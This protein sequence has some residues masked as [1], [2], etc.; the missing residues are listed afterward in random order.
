[1]AVAGKDF[2][3]QPSKFKAEAHLPSF[4][5]GQL[6]EHGP[7]APGELA[8][9][10]A[11]GDALELPA[12]RGVLGYAL[13]APASRAGKDQLAGGQFESREGVAIAIA[14]GPL[15]PL[16]NILFKAE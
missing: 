1:L 15:Y 8:L 13:L 3:G 2:A 6:I 10:Q 12:R 14:H 7:I 11:P 16:L 4:G 5:F 9:F